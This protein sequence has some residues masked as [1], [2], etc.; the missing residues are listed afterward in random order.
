VLTVRVKKT[1]K[2]QLTSNCV[3]AKYVCRLWRGNSYA[4]RA[5]V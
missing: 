4:F 2:K 5:G 3:C 1:E